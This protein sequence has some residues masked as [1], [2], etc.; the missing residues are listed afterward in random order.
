MSSIT[1]C[2]ST[3]RDGSHPKA[4]RYTPDEV[5]RVARGLDGAGVPI[6][7]VS[8]GDGLGGSS[9]NYGFSEV[10]ELELLE[11]ARESVERA[12]LAVLL[13]PG[14]GVKEDLAAARERGASVAR[15]ATHC[16]EADIAI[17][18]LCLARELEL[19]TF[20]FLMMAHMTPP[21]ALAEQARIMADAGAEVVYVTDSAGAL[22]PDGVR[23]RV[24]ALRDA[25]GDVEVG[26]HGHQNLGLGVG[27]SLAA[28]ASGASWI[29]ACT[30]GL[31]AGAGNT[32]TEALVAACDKAGIET[33]IDVL[34]IAEVA[35]TV[36]APLMPRE[37]ILDR[38][39]LLLGYAGVYSSFLLHAR[40]AE[41]RSGVP[42]AELLI[43][44]GRRGAVGGQEDWIID[45][46]EEMA[47]DRSGARPA[48]RIAADA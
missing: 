9:F 29:D 2:D 5:A 28:I 1:I 20:G 37:Q 7:E 4:H 18:H 47:A 38:D 13:L 11:T 39:A 30:R 31:G 42:A 15:V 23:A 8:H 6:I 10:D 19:T 21:E 40:R 35:E 17:Q 12:R 48:E 36:V 41:E 27:N 25:L 44:L 46:A 14:I 3:L 24:E 26:F 16:T 32:P 45:L 22:L 43:E 34:A 33:G